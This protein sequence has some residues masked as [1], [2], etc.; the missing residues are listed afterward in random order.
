MFVGGGQVVSHEDLAARTTPASKDLM[1]QALNPEASKD[2]EQTLSPAAQEG[3]N[4][5][6]RA[7]QHAVQQM[8]LKVNNGTVS[9]TV[10]SV[11]DTECR[12]CFEQNR[13]HVH[14]VVQGPP[15]MTYLLRRNAWCASISSAKPPL[16]DIMVT[17]HALTCCDA[18]DKRLIS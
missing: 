16:C 5:K 17:L 3:P 7:A 13:G 15:S 9:L 1:N 11:W 12:L 4:A 2:V 6:E 8:A 10:S 18:P 14:F